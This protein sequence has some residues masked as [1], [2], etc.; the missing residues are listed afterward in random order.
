MKSPRI[1]LSIALLLSLPAR[2]HAADP[3]EML[4]V[5]L[6]VAASSS[7]SSVVNFH[8]TLLADASESMLDRKDAVNAI[9]A[10]QNTKMHNSENEYAILASG[11]YVW[12]AIKVDEG[13]P[14]YIVQAG[15]QVMAHA[16]IMVP[17]AAEFYSQTLQNL[18]GVLIEHKATVLAD[19]LAAATPSSPDTTF[20]AAKNY[21]W[22]RVE[23]N[24][25]T[26]Y[27]PLADGASLPADVFRQQTLQS[28]PE[29]TLQTKDAMVAIIGLQNPKTNNCAREQELFKSGNYSWQPVEVEG[30]RTTYI[31]QGNGVYMDEETETAVETPAVVAESSSGWLASIANVLPTLP[32]LPALFTSASISAEPAQSEFV[33]AL[34]GL[35]Q[36][37][38]RELVLSKDN[39]VKAVPRTDYLYKN[40]IATTSLNKDSQAGWECDITD[41]HLT[42]KERITLKPSG[43]RTKEY[44]R[45][46]AITKKQL[47]HGMVS[48]ELARFN[49]NTDERAL[50]RQGN[51]QAD[52]QKLLD[53]MNSRRTRL[54]G[55]GKLQRGLKLLSAIETK[56][57]E[58]RIKNLMQLRAIEPKL[59][60]ELLATRAQI[61]AQLNQPAHYDFIFNVMALIEALKDPSFNA[62][63]A[64]LARGILSQFTSV[65]QPLAYQPVAEMAQGVV[66]VYNS[67]WRSA[68]EPTAATELRTVTA[69]ISTTEAN[70]EAARK[71]NI[72]HLVDKYTQELIAHKLEQERLFTVIQ[73]EVVQQAATMLTVPVTQ[74]N[75][76][77][78]KTA[79]ENRVPRTFEVVK[80]LITGAKI[81]PASTL[82]QWCTQAQQLQQY[83]KGLQAAIINESNADLKKLASMLA[84]LT[85]DSREEGRATV[86]AI[87]GLLGS[88]ASR[89][90]L[91]RQK[92][93]VK[94]RT[95][96][97]VKAQDPSPAFVDSLISAVDA[98]VAQQLA[99]ANKTTY[100][101]AA[102]SSSNDA[103]PKKQTQQPKKSSGKGKGKGHGPAG[104]PQRK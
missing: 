99:A 84:I 23:M 92:T 73:A 2:V 90:D 63:E 56:S 14:K 20:D 21:L 68:G 25:K 74:V 86:D 48:Q 35:L 30:A 81:R 49:K 16:S 80:E 103:Q 65:N 55:T 45:D 36:E 62:T 27:V 78:E 13:R 1:T 29:E 18:D 6:P 10:L 95:A 70:L 71:D 54:E 28:I 64:D 66:S 12:Q 88:S 42:G 33:P 19:V 43:A 46:A 85:A 39:A 57:A 89:T 75:G 22:Q 102:A 11:D 94:D 37:L 100:A 72:G 60:A 69:L 104:K 52:Q 83:T 7:G 24:G 58:Q 15:E 41:N 40:N 4:P 32:T 34:Q 31:V 47:E 50:A 59:N 67:W 96:F 76:E 97:K 79:A 87:R 93:G 38:D 101:Q 82:A 17:T 98:S 3:R 5:G 26:T 77:A 51:S 44:Y 9:V 91:N 61:Q 53:L 8:T